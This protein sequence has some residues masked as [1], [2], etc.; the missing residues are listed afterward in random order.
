MDTRIG[1]A[2][3]DLLVGKGRRVF[4]IGGGL[5]WNGSTP[6]LARAKSVDRAIAGKC[7]Q[8]ADRAGPLRI[9][10]PGVAPQTD[11]DILQGILGFISIT[12][13]T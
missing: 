3:F 10:P 4:D 5:Y 8:P 13:D 9:I 1:L 11:I 6:D 12:Q 2:C 7:R